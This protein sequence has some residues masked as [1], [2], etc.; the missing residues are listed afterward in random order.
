MDVYSIMRLQFSTAQDMYAIH[1]IQENANT[2]KGKYGIT[3]RRNRPF[4]YQFLLG[5]I[6][7]PTGE[8]LTVCINGYWARSWY[9]AAFKIEEGRHTPGKLRIKSPNHILVGA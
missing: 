2:V 5:R 4:G 6:H 9:N 7:N 1:C 3:G 8:I